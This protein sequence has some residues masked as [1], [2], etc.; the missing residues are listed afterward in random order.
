MSISVHLHVCRRTCCPLAIIFNIP[1]VY[2]ISM[3]ENFRG[4]FQGT[5]LGGATISIVTFRGFF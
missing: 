2:V 4:N 3:N 1:T 5:K